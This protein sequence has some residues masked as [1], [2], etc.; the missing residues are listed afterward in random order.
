MWQHPT[1]TRN[2]RTTHSDGA[3]IKA[4][5]SRKKKNKSQKHI[6]GY[7]VVVVVVI[8]YGCFGAICRSC[9]VARI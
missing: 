5:N 8:K 9:L 6:G 2:E 4:R 1:V 7:H 3:K